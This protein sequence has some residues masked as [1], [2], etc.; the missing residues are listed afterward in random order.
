MIIEKF[1]ADGNITQYTAVSI[2]RF[3]N[4]CIAS[5]WPD[6]DLLTTVLGLALNGGG[7][8]AEINVCILGVVTDTIFDF[9]FRKPVYIGIA[10]YMTQKIPTKSVYII[11]KAVAKH[12][13]FVA[14]SQ[15]FL[16]KL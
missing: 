11:G 6:S 9:T 3:D 15:P 13:I 7:D 2:G 1:L 10:G 5:A 8:G 14:P 4:T 16:L 12:S